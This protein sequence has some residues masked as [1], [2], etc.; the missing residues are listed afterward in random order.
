VLSHGRHTFNQYVVRVPAQHRDPLVAHLKANSIG[1]EVYY[2]LSL[3]QQECV[4]H[5]G[6][7]TGD[8]P[9][10]EAA[11]ASVLALPMYPELEEAQQRRVM[12]VCQAYVKQALKRVA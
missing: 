8:F 7:K 6:H 11:A 12:D 3:H 5:L 1:C 9:H 4:Q 10:S 2:P